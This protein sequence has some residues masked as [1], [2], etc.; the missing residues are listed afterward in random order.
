M[1]KYL[2][3]G[4]ILCAFC[5]VILPIWAQESPTRTSKEKPKM[6]DLL[7]D[8]LDHKLDASDFLIQADGFIPVPQLIT[9]PAL[10]DIGVMLAAV[11]IKPNKVQ[12]KDEY[13]PPNITAAVAG[14]T[15]NQTWLLGAMRIASLPKYR[16]KYRAGLAY[17]NVNMDFYRD[18]PFIGERKFSFNFRM[19]PVF[20]SVLK[21]IG[22]T[23]VY[24]GLEYLFINADVGANFELEDFPD[25]DERLR[26][27]HNLSSVGVDLEYD[28]RDNVFTPNKGILITSNYRQNAE[29]TGSDYE[30]G[31][32][33]FGV[34]YYFQPTSRWVSGFRLDNK[35][36]FGDAP[37]YAMPGISLR[38][39]PINRYQG[40]RTYMLET[41]Q[42][43]DFT[44]R[45]SILAFGGM[46]KAPTQEV[47]FKDAL[48][49]YNYGTGFRYL[50]AR[51]F[52]LRMGV[53]VAWSN[54]DF[55]YYITFGSAWNNRN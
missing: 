46:A 24:V 50:L 19:T 54:N 29:W 3:K 33:T 18:L 14:Y 32:L 48:L 52:G 39:V 37:F 6:K 17:A 25:F 55:G 9:E 47:D 7:H 2:K 27:S 30:Y 34:L 51:K 31:T 11:F 12:L 42:R 13:V 22:R 1:H 4:I 43:Y 26:K 53:D 35:S 40:D 38:G 15:G 23:H 21:E 44:K 28:K 45:W 41:E 10:G 49:V 8:S 16:M 36:Q 5:W 20:A